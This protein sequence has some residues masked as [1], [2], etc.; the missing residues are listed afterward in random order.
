MSRILLSITVTVNFGC[1]WNDDDD[2]DVDDGDDDEDGGDDD[3]DN[4]DDNTDNENEKIWRIEEGNKHIKWKAI[5]APKPADDCDE[6]GDDEMLEMSYRDD[7]NPWPMKRVQG[8][9]KKGREDGAGMG[10]IK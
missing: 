5:A 1:I 7:D 3:D 10:N 2:D 6:I 9:S 4:D 8:T